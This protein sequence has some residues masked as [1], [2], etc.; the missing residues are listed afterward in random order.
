MGSVRVAVTSVAIWEWIVLLLLL[1]VALFP[2][3]P[4]SFL[5]LLIPFFWLLHYRVGERLIP[6]TPYN[7]GLAIMAIMILVSLSVTFDFALSL[8][9]IVG[10]LYG[11]ALL[12]AATRLVK[13]RKLGIWW[14]W[15]TALVVGVTIALLGLLG[16]TWLPPYAALNVVRD[17]LPFGLS[18][19]PGAVG[20]VIN[21]NE[22][23][24]TLVWIL[25]LFIAGLIGL[26]RTLHKRGGWLTLLL[27]A[28]TLLLS[29]VIVAT[30]SRGGLLALVLSTALIISLFVPRQWRLVVLVVASV[31]SLVWYFSYG[32]VLDASVPNMQQL[33]LSSRTEIW[34]RALMAIADFPLTGVSVNGFRRLIEVLY[35]PFT[36]TPGL[37]LGHAHNHLLQA[38]LDLGIPGLVGYLALWMVA[39][40]MLYRT[41]QRM[42]HQRAEHHRDYVLAA[43]LAG[44]L[45]AGWLFGMLDTISLG[46]R[47]GFIWWLLLAMSGGVHYL[48][49]VQEET[50]GRRRK[51][52]VVEEPVDGALPEPVVAVSDPQTSFPSERPRS[53]PRM[54][55]RPPAD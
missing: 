32:S 14:I 44:S 4:Q 45:L 3:G 46:A 27:A 48:V 30:Q 25:P 35:P 28:G 47:P 55:Y 54:R 10:I 13:A 26:P 36:I 31:I 24:G 40:G 17:S 19:I 51:R 15:A 23:A 49:M 5:L 8:T 43:G 2:I 37:D 50:A 52:V 41:L 34:S 29:A 39:A 12:L 20:G 9:K 53:R 42:V 22:L 6:N 33:E 7:L 11:M 21:E 16:T 38:A 1:P 18:A